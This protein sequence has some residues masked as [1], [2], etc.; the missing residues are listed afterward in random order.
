[1]SADVKKIL[2]QFS[3]DIE[4]VSLEFA[5]PWENYILSLNKWVSWDLGFFCNFAESLLSWKRDFFIRI[6]AKVRRTFP[7]IGFLKVF[8]F[9]F[10]LI[11]YRVRSCHRDAVGPIYPI[12]L[13]A[14]LIFVSPLTL[15]PSRSTSIS[16]V[17]TFTVRHFFS[18]TRYTFLSIFIVGL[19]FFINRSQLR[20]SQIRFSQNIFSF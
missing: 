6:F 11:P 9:V 7:D 1:M 10:V 15:P 12:P 16:G 4:W 5:I 19:F 8:L 20:N 13:H 2:F 18:N 14:L 17:W 3:S